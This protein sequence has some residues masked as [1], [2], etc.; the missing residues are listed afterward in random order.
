MTVAGEKNT[1]A[2]D[3]SFLD[4]YEIEMSASDKKSKKKKKSGQ[5]ISISNGS[6][7]K[8]QRRHHDPANIIGITFLTLL[9]A[10]ILISLVHLN[11][12]LNEVN[13]EVNERQDV[14]TDM[15]NKEAQY[16]LTIESKFTDDFVRKYAE[17]T[18]NMTPV[19]SAQK[20]FISLSE[21]DKGEVLE[22]SE[23][24]DVFTRFRKALGL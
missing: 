11:A 24:S 16:K 12:K 21:G 4:S 17:N 1:E 2:Y 7:A 3:F 13:E 9:A 20:Q 10:A 14:L 6:S 18:L 19:K 8:A 15:Q 5:I 23:S 22:E